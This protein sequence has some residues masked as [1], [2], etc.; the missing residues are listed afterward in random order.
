MRRGRVDGDA[1]KAL[2][3]NR[4]A[5][6]IWVEITPHNFHAEKRANIMGYD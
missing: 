5:C 2:D 1:V 3:L 6:I 4:D